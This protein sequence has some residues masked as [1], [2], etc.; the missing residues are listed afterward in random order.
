MIFITGHED[1][2]AQATVM[3]AGAFAFFIKPLDD[4]KFLASVHRALGDPLPAKSGLVERARA[5]LKSDR[6]LSRR[7]QRS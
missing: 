4:I 6:R 7:A 5:L 1:D 3:Q 2:A